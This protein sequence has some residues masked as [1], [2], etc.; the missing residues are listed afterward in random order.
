MDHP[1]YL[2]RLIELELINRERRVVERWIR[3]ARFPAV[4]SLDAFIF[5]AIQ[6]PNKMLVW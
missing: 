3:Q 5:E 6:S 4:K 2:L 1:R